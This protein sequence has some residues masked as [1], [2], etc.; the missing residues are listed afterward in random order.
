[1]LQNASGKL[2]LVTFIFAWELACNNYAIFILKNEATI[3]MYGCENQWF[4]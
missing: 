1:M 2:E 3:Y 4:L